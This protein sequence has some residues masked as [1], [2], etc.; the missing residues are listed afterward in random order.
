[1]V[2]SS[3]VIV[4]RYLGG[5]PGRG[6]PEP[7]RV[8]VFE[9]RF[10]VRA[11]KWGW[12]IGFEAVA[13][14]G[15]LQP[16]P[17][18]NGY[19]LPVVWTPPGDVPHTL[20]LSGGDASRLRFLLAQ[21][22][23]VARLAAD[24]PP[25]PPPPRMGPRPPSRWQLELQRMRALTTAALTAALTAL[26]LL[27]GVTVVLLG[28]E[29]G[30]GHWRTDLSRLRQIQSELQLASERNSAAD[31]SSALQALTDE[32]HRLESYNGDAGNT[33]SS[34]TEVQQIC[35]TVGVVLF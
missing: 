35:V 16:A 23:T 1:M 9:D 26:V 12:R 22:V 17:D 18:G 31:M 3:P 7:V 8:T 32:C 30:G 4:L 25:P 33:G 34:F 10:E 21:A 6:R 28:R 24:Q 20:M 2:A 11:Q 5:C 29:A 13:A 27:I 19:L 15:E 14:V